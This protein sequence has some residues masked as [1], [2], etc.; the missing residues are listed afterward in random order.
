[1]IYE[2]KPFK[3]KLIK[4]DLVWY[5]EGT[6][7]YDRGGVPYMEIRRSDCKILRFGHSK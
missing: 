6:L 3:A 5:V 7:N 2:S 4:N 1:M